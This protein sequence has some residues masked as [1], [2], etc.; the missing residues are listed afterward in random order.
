MSDNLQDNEKKQEENIQK[1]SKQKILKNL[2][3]DLH[4][5]KPFNEVKK[6]FNKLLKNVSP[7]E[8]SE[9]ENTLIMEGFPPEEI[10]RLCEVHVQIFETTL[11]KNKKPDKMPGH[12]IHTFMEEN[13]ALKKIIK[14]LQV[15]IK[16]IIKGKNDISLEFKN[17]LENLKLVNVHYI[18]K[19]NQLFPFLE[20]N[21]FFGPSKVM[22]GKH[23]EIRKYIKD[24]ENYYIE[25]NY[26]GLKEISGKLFSSLKNMIFM[27]E[28]ILFPT[29]LKKLNINDWIEIRK[30]EKELGYVWIIPGNIWDTEI[31]ALLN[32]NKLKQGT[33]KEKVYE[34]KNMN[35]DKILLDIGSL[36]IERI[37]LMLKKLPVD[38]TFVDEN[39]K[40]L[41]YSDS[42]DR[43]FPRSPEIIGREVQNCHP[44][45]SVH[46]VNKIIES[47]KNK[48]KDSAK[49][50][51]NLNNKL[52][53]IQ[54]IPVYDDK[55]I[56][57][58]VLEITQDIT[59]IKKLEGERR[60]LE[61]S[62]S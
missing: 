21:K 41:Y 33:E 35:N 45:K 37:N 39:N 52:V 8:I 13:K 22:W 59:E 58:G 49:F 57:K 55:G 2:I 42:K 30:S 14:K 29:S 38:I 12:P 24:F 43:I 34:E 7:E 61:F 1:E 15:L 26:E 32:K 3:K 17:E 56:Y 48:E 53:Y 19:E 46:I 9:M 47:F 10:Q 23:D 18:R 25:K 11:A 50:W 16:K 62:L 27:E 6:Q 40:V 5:G 51:I 20:K 4:D 36:D 60:L 31:A 54:Y 44:P 28:K